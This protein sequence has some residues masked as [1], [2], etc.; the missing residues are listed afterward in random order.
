MR[1]LK[2]RVIYEDVEA[3]EVGSGACDESLAVTLV[4]DISS[5]GEGS[6]SRLFDHPH[7]LLRVRMLV[8]V[9]DQNVGPLARERERYGAPD[10]AVPAGDERRLALQAAVPAVALLAVVGPGLHISLE[11]R[12]LLRLLGVGRLR[13]SLARIDCCALVHSPTSRSSPGLREPKYQRMPLPK[14]RVVFTDACDAGSQAPP[15]RCS[16]AFGRR[17]E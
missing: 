10:A 3:A 2:G 4:A 16:E 5:D 13:C 12:R 7:G 9:R 1:H 8:E 17:S 15:R 14:Q 6:A 11:S